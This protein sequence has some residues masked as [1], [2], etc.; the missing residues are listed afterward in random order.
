MEEM[1]RADGFSAT[2]YYI[3]VHCMLDSSKGVDDESEGDVLKERA[4]AKGTIRP[5]VL[6]P[7]GNDINWARIVRRYRYSILCHQCPQSTITSSWQVYIDKLIPSPTAA[8]VSRCG[9]LPGGFQM[10]ECPLGR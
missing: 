1:N 5:R 6:D 4:N 2:L 3:H 8:G 10:L 9:Q 7:P